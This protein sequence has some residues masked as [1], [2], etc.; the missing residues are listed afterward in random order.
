MQAMDNKRFDNDLRAATSASLSPHLQGRYVP[1][2]FQRYFRDR[3]SENS[4][5]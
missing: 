4:P 1:N 3:D 5:F 2:Q